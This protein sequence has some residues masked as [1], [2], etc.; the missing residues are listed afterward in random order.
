MSASE[1][2][3]AYVL[4]LL[5]TFGRVR[6][7]RFFGGV[8]L[9]L[10]SVQFAMIMGNT[11]Y[12]AVDDSTRPQ[13]EQ[14]G[15]TPFSYAT[16]KSRVVVGKYYAVPEDVLTDPEQLRQWARQSLAIAAASRTASTRKRKPVER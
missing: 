6:A 2:Y 4:E 3:T 9:S 10:E 13:Y 16:K 14:A 12:F 1:Q 11:V 15:M 5:E 8:G 7:S